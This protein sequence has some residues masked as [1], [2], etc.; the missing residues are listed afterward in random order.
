MFH[1]NKQISK[2]GYMRGRCY[3]VAYN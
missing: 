3:R 1:F 2:V